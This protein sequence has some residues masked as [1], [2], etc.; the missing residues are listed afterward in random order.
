V[1]PIESDLER[2]R[3]IVKGRVRKDLKRYISSGEM[4]AR[5]GDRLVSVPLPEIAIPRLRYGPNPTGGIGQGEGDPGEPVERGEGGQG[6]AG[7]LP[8][9]LNLAP[10]QRISRAVPLR[11]DHLILA[12]LNST[13]LRTTG[14]YLRKFNFSVWVRGFFLVT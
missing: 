7:D 5:Q 13:C 6:A 8:A 11:R 12:S 2:F 4:I 3:Q 14:S 9:A 1:L 10:P